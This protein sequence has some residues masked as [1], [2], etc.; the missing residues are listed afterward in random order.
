MSEEPKAPEGAPG[1]GNPAKPDDDAKGQPGTGIVFLTLSLPILVAIF[2][3]GLAEHHFGSFVGV[4]LVVAAGAFGVG[5]LLGFLFGVPR[6]SGSADGSA[7][8]TP[9]TGLL[10]PNSN[11]VQVSDW[12]TKVLIG[13]TL[14][15]FRELVNSIGSFATDTLAPALGNDDT[16]KAFAIALLVAS[17]AAGFLVTYVFTR[18]ILQARFNAADHL[19][20]DQV[21]SK[22]ASDPAVTKQISEQLAANPEPELLDQVAEKTAEKLRKK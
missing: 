3:Y 14:V 4:S 22:L 13:A 15:Q 20:V 9:G 10:S 6:P 7:S 19:L 1:A 16:A 17:F 2:V 11:L 12:L 18:L 21:A 8:S 5:A